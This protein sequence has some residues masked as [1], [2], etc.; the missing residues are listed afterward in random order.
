MWRAATQMNNVNKQ[1]KKLY[2]P[3]LTNNIEAVGETTHQM[4][5]LHELII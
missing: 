2:I 1:S 4:K 3:K 5:N